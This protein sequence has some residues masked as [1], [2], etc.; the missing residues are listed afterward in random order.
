[1]SPRDEVLISIILIIKNKIKEYY[2]E[3]SALFG[4]LNVVR[5][6]TYYISLRESLASVVKTLASNLIKLSRRTR[7]NCCPCDLRMLRKAPR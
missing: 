3:P 2:G 1:M 7:P 6:S 5:E 4:L